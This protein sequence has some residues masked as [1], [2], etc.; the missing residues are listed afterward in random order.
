MWERHRRLWI[1]NAAL[2]TVRRFYMHTGWTDYS[3]YRNSPDKLPPLII[4][5]TAY[6]RRLEGSY[7]IID[8]IGRR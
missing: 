1:L 2:A 5:Q 8:W 6:F 7:A 3:R 4:W